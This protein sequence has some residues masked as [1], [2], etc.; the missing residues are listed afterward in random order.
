[1]IGI[2]FPKSTAPFSHANYIHTGTP[3]SPGGIYELAIQ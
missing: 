2:L 1:L 3:S